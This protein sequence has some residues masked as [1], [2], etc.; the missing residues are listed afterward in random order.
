MLWKEMVK[1]ISEVARDTLKKMVIHNVPPLPCYYEKEFLEVARKLGKKN[2]LKAAEKDRDL[3][4]KRLNEVISNTEDAVGETK[5]VLSGFE[6][7]A[8]KCINQL[9]AQLMKTST[10]GLSKHELSN[11]METLAGVRERLQKGLKDAY[12]KLE[13]Q[14]KMFEELRKQL[15]QDAL[16]QVL[17]R[18]SWDNDLKEMLEKAWQ[19]ENKKLNFSLILA[20][21][22]FFKK[23]NDLHGHIVGDAVL[24][25]FASLLRDHFAEYG[26]V[27][28]YGGEE[29]GIILPGLSPE[30]AVEYVEEFRQCLQRTCFTAQRGKIKLRITASFGV[31]GYMPSSNAEEL[32]SAA[33][34]A[35]YK[36][37]QTGRNRVEVAK[38]VHA[39]NETQAEA[40]I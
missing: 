21:I 17:N 31:C 6:Q 15:H 8:S 9:E 4:E 2:V 20:D 34:K 24:K 18:R 16:T 22:D 36:A 14:S 32:V 13:E 40:A 3:I 37:K 10:E 28:R 25:Q 39:A 30:K 27:Y 38:M 23:V 12:Q 26:T 11:G 1:D 33:D 5:E 19:E 7:D 29:F 35:L